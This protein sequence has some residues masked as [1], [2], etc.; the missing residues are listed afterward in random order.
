MSA[1]YCPPAAQ[2]DILHADDA[3][4]V[5]AKP[6]GLL[7]VPG[8]GAGKADCLQARLAD[9][10]GAALT[11]HRLD[12]ETSGLMVFARTP[13]AQAALSR[14]FRERNVEKRYLAK[15]WGSPTGDAGEIALPLIA[16]WPNRPRQ[17]V[18]LQGGKPSLTRWHVVSR[19]GQTARLDL[20]ALTGRTHQL[21]VHLAAIGHPILGDSLY[22]PGEV[23]T[24]SARMCLHACR[25]GF[26]H[27]VSGAWC[28]FEHEPDF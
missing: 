2:P 4:I 1:P 17:K 14:A 19:S 25:L 27:P 8:R 16:D 24:A 12:M 5:A 11:V 20:E 22:A 28:G 21:R 26:A 7:S 15:V 6:A 23:R 3:L 18:D 9:R 13:E 10:Y